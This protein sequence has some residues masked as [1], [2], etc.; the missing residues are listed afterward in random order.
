MLREPKPCNIDYMKETKYYFSFLKILIICN[1]KQ[2]NK[3]ENL[4]KTA[5]IVN[6]MYLL[7]GKRQFVC[8]TKVWAHIHITKEE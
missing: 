5:Y 4:K 1:V 3:T 2:L 7:P 8:T 6:S